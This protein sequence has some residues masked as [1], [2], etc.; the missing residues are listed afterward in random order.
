[1]RADHSVWRACRPLFPLGWSKQAKIFAEDL[2]FQQCE[3]PHLWQ[4]AF[5]QLVFGQQGGDRFILSRE[6]AIHLVDLVLQ[7][8]DM[9]P[10][11][12]LIH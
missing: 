5:V 8:I 3:K 4:H 7:V 12:A 10:E 11:Q 9:C 6:T 2:H 1:M